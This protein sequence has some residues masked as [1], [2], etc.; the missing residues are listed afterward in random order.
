MR[1]IELIY[2]T[3]MMAA[4]VTAFPQLRRLWVV[5]NSDEF[6]LA[7]WIAWLVAQVAALIYAISIA[8]VPYVIVN[9]LW[10]VFYTFMVILIFKYRDSS[11][12]ELAYARI[13]EED[14]DKRVYNKQ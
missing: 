2:V 9:L 10:I 11:K 13:V 14:N 12:R 5:K 6:N 8:S 4:I 1:T 7:S 3:S